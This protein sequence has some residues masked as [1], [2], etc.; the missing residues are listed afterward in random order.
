MTP[1]RTGPRQRRTR[2][3]GEALVKTKQE[4]SGGL[5]GSRE[6]QRT[7]LRPMPP[8]LIRRTLQH[9]VYDYL[10]ESLATGELAPGQR[11]TIRDVAERIGT[12]IM[13]VREAFRRLT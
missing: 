10:R 6:A 12:S 7:T 5:S 1:R 8:P 13:P 11:L 4:L 3:A 9:N 2:R